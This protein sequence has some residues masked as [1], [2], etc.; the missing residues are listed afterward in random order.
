[1]EKEE[2][3]YNKQFVYYWYKELGWS[4]NPF[5]YRYAFPISDYISNYLK[6]R[7]KLNYFIIEK[8]PLCLIT[9]NEGTGKTT[10]ILWLK[11]E[12][13]Q[14][15]DKLFVEYI[16]KST[17]LVDFVKT[18]IMP[19]LN[20]KEKIVISSYVLHIGKT[21]NLISDVNLRYIY[22]SIYL[23]K[24][25]LDFNSIKGY[26][27]SRL[28]EKDM[29]LLV[30]DTD[31]LNEQTVKFLQMMI[32]SDLKIQI[33][34]ASKKE[35]LEIISK[36]TNVIKIQLDGL[37]YEDMKEMISKRIKCV[38]GNDSE[39]LNEEHLKNIYQ[40]CNKNP[41]TFL[42]LCKDKVIRIA[43]SRV[44]EGKKF[45][46]KTSMELGLKSYSDS[47]MKDN[48]QNNK[49]YEIK[50]LNNNSSEHYEIK[51]VKPKD[52]VLPV[53][54]EKEKRE[55]I[56]VNGEKNSSELNNNKKQEYKHKKK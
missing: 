53:K 16:N 6:E 9:G 14:Y 45:D 17:N 48:S 35:N 8:E 25:D 3:Q 41:L 18:L 26:L 49:P 20:K 30:D 38:G 13:M 54:V 47:P 34:M 27:N 7:K 52:E 44:S 2:N 55:A 22:E 46:V 28:K 11:Q 12:L 1:M 19:F 56:P 37:N 5:E 10:L 15:K 36:K 29:A 4:S 42:N 43:V 31:E 24:K 32:N 40:K 51:S 50:V 23:K 39:P 33:V 21:A